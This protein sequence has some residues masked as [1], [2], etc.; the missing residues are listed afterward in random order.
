MVSYQWFL[1]FIPTGILATK[2]QTRGGET[3]G[4]PLIGVYLTGILLISKE[5]YDMISRE[6]RR[7]CGY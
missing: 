1:G 6:A 5:N 4:I 3:R 2:E 7:N